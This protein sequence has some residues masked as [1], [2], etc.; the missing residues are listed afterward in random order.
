MLAIKQ[1][2]MAAFWVGVS[3]MLAGHAFQP[4]VGYELG[5]S[6]HQGRLG[7]HQAKSGNA[8]NP[9]RQHC[10]RSWS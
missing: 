7:L 2:E 5:E 1:A 4:Q 6:R 3:M 9:D 8:R 10:E